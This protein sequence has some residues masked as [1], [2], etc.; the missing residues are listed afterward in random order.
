M[1]VLAFPD[2]GGKWHISS[3]GAAYPMWSRSGR[4][5]FFESLDHRIMV[6]SYTVHGDS[7]WPQTASGSWR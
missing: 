2:K 5:L 7:F 1:Y 3:A 4:E 6:P